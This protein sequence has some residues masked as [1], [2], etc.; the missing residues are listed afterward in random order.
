MAFV[1]RSAEAS[2]AIAC[3]RI[4]RE[5]GAETPWMVPLDD[6]EP[7]ADSWRDLLDTE[8]AW[9][10][11]Q[12]GGV[13][14]FCVREDDNI[15]GLYVARAARN[16]GAGKRLLDLAKAERDWITVWAYEANTLARKFYR[17]EG[18]M[19]IGREIQKG[20]NLVDVEHRWLRSP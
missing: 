17:R 10:A 18:L 12:D 14:G 16:F 8:T 9:V 2:D 4:I 3:A 15:T 13:V 20:T 19:E 7:M 1:Y 6:L 11:E 5:W